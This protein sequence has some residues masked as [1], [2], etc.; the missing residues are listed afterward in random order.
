[1]LRVAG[2]QDAWWEMLPEQARQLPAELARVDAF[3]DDERFIAPWRAVFAE[4]LGR[5]SV[6]VETLL[7]LLYLKHRYQLGYETL[8]R[9]V[10]DSLSWRRFCRIPLASP[11]PHPTTLLKL[12]RRSGARTVEEM[13]AALLGKLVED[14][15][16]RCRKLRIDTTV[17]EAD[18]DHPTDADLLEHGVR[19]LGQLVGRIKASGAARRTRFRDRSRSAG[20]R[21]KEISRTLRRRTGQALGEIDRLTGEVAAVARATLRDVAAVERNARRAL[22]KRPSGRLAHLV[23]ELAE[24]AAGTR[25]LLEQTALRLAGIRTIPDRLVSLADPDARPIRKGKP[26][27]PTQFG[28][29]ALVAE[30]ERGFIVDHQ[31][32]RGNPA[33]APQLVPSVKRAVSLTGRP[34]GTVVAD[35]GFG[36]AAND[37]ALAE[38]GVQRIGLQRA[39]KP[40][41][42]RREYEQSRRFRCMRNWRV[43]IEARISHLKRSFGFRRTRLRRLAGAQ[44]WAG[45]GIFAYNLQRMTV[46]S[47]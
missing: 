36:T 16:V 13:N 30:D 25:R 33:D 27:H 17:I 14:K 38:L 39:G 34:P 28:Y 26:Q 6:P 20:R 37:L 32:Q 44:I 15:L 11:V 46:L 12:V 29:T 23:G 5:P 4:R 43:G 9:E 31:V 40:G 8:C 22:G 47:R 19:K 35:R 2:V 3:L 41:E 42:A 7:R 45:L 18:I 1:M 21:L 10:A 24:T